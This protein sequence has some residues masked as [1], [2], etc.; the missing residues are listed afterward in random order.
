[1]I[2]ALTTLLLVL[3]AGVPARAEWFL[4]PAFPNLQFTN[5][6]DFQHAGDG[7]NRVFVVEQAGDIWVFERSDTVST[8]RKFLDVSSKLNSGYEAGLLGL[9]FHPDYENNGYFYINYTSVI[10]QNTVAR[11]TVSADPDSADPT[12]ELIVLAESQLGNY[13]NGGQLAFGPDGYLYIS[14]GDGG[15]PSSS[16]DLTTFTGSILR[17]NVDTTANGNNYG[18]PPDNPFAGNGSGYKEEIF[19]YGFRN[20]WRFA[21]DPVT[22]MCIAGDV[23]QATWE[24]LDHVTPGANFGWPLMEGPDC[25]DPPSCDTTGAGLNAPVWTY[26]HAVG[27]AVVAGY[28]YRGA[29]HPSLVGKF[30]YGDYDSGIIWALDY[31]GVNPPTNEIVTPLAPFVL[32][33]GTDQDGELYAT[34]YDGY[35]YTLKPVVS[36]APSQPITASALLGNYPNPFN[37]STTI[38]F[39]LAEPSPVAVGIYDVRGRRV[40][41][42]VD[43]DY[44]MGRNS[45]AWDGRDDAGRRVPSGVYFCRLTVGARVVDS[46]QMILI[47]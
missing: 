16:Q 15:V 22:G 38:A 14:R 7:T 13:H 26:T 35:I 41:T 39:T 2:R 30:I 10:N 40:R 23:G 1:M 44:G 21:L 9:A 24:E 34:S 25:Y 31:D 36:H 18:I 28:F 45:V 17:I 12:S 4:A 11:Y 6:T 37:P 32:S 29:D 43:S 19:A 47:K 33:F 27:H 3:I 46:R 8:K 42:L 5:P 20:A